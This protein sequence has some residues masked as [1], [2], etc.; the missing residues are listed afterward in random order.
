MR[1]P[2]G[3]TE[4]DGSHLAKSLSQ[5]TAG[6]LGS[7][8]Q[9]ARALCPC[10]PGS[11]LEAGIWAPSNGPAQEL[12]ASLGDIFPLLLPRRTSPG[13]CLCPVSNRQK[14]VPGVWTRAGGINSVMSVVTKCHISALERAAARLIPCYYSLT[15]SQPSPAVNQQQFTGLMGRG[16]EKR[17]EKGKHS[18]LPPLPKLIL[19]YF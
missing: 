13:I 5:Q 17:E 2:V 8:A 3:G 10:P 15:G 9:A 11:S 19:S 16:R 1:G 12:P 6:N 7:G 18:L 14:P 4:T